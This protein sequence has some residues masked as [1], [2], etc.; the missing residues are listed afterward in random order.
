MNK[1]HVKFI[2]IKAWMDKVLANI[3]VS[4]YKREVHNLWK[5]I[6]VK[7]EEKE[8]GDWSPYKFYKWLLNLSS[9]SSHN[10]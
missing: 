1:Y 6:K 7:L 10:H 3:N 8:I 5:L 2:A 4:K 9:K